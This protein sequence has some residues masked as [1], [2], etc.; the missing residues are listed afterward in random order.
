MKIAF[1]KLGF[2]KNARGKFGEK[3]PENLKVARSK[4]EKSARETWK[5]PVANSGFFSQNLP[6]SK[7]LLALETRLSD[8]PT[9]PRKQF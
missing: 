1:G 2:Q 8:Q 7:L 4:L 5:L 9:L 6:I 3:L